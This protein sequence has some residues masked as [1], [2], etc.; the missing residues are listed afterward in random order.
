MQVHNQ[1]TKDT[2]KKQVESI[3]YLHVVRL[4]GGYVRLFWG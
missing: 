4:L 2:G 3:G 1:P